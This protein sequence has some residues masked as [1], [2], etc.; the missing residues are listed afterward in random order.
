MEKSYL[1]I[2]TDEL[3]YDLNQLN[4]TDLHFW[5]PIEILNKQKFQEVYFYC[6]NLIE[7][8]ETLKNNYIPHISFMGDSIF[9]SFYN[10]TEEY[11]LERFWFPEK[12]HF[13]QEYIDLFLNLPNIE[14][15]PIAI[16]YNPLFQNDID[17]QE[18][19]V[20]IK[21]L[22]LKY[23]NP[24]YFKD[25]SLQNDEIF[26]LNNAAI[27]NNKHHFVVLGLFGDY[28]SIKEPTQ[29]A[30]NLGILKDKE[31]VVCE[32]AQTCKDRGLGFIKFEQKI[33][34]CIGIKLFQQN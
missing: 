21:Q 16:V 18:F 31:C 4:Y 2:K 32:F 27:I 34:S 30:I 12:K 19:F 7:I 3:S 11:N 23:K 5:K 17:Y 25:L 14:N 10:D 13:T 22:N 20:F 15:T 8:K 29:Q 24:L 1:F 6:T 33:S 9:S 26:S 28:Y